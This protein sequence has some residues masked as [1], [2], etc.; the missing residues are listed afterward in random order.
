MVYY[1][2]RHEWWVGSFILKYYLCNYAVQL[3]NIKGM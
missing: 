2:F 1:G 3:G